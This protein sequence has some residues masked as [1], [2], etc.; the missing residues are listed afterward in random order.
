MATNLIIAI[1]DSAIGGDICPAGMNV[2]RRVQNSDFR[3]SRMHR[4]EVAVIDAKVGTQGTPPCFMRP[5][6][7]KMFALFSVRN[8][9]PRLFRTDPMLVPSFHRTPST[10]A[11]VV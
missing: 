3:D 2:R 6:P 5:P 11:V 1:F 7:V 8:I 4:N 9:G 10:G